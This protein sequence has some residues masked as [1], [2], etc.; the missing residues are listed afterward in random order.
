MVALWCFV[1]T[2]CALLVI[3][4]VFWCFAVVFVADCWCLLFWFGF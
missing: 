4:F 3:N 1:C 2:D